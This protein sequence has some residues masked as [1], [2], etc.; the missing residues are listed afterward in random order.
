MVVDPLLVVAG[1]GQEEVGAAALV[2]GNEQVAAVVAEVERDLGSVKLRLGRDHLAQWHDESTAEEG[3]V[4]AGNG[5]APEKV[6][7]QSSSSLFGWR[8]SYFRR[9]PADKGFNLQNNDD[10]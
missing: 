3:E 7:T 10:H 5:A 6:P 1:P 4:G 2:Q 8:I 9:S